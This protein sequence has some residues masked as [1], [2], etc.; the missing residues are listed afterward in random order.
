MREVSRPSETTAKIKTC[1]SSTRTLPVRK[2]RWLEIL[3]PAYPP[4]PP[5]GRPAKD[6]SCL[7]LYTETEKKCCSTNRELPKKYCA[8][9]K[10]DYAIAK[11]HV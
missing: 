8:F 3:S 9:G 10:V 11:Q 6:V 1:V 7:I 4:T 2:G 5:P